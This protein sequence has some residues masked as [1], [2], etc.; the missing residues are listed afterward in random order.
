MN[1]CHYDEPI[2]VNNLTNSN[3]SSSRI[4][5][6]FNEAFATTSQKR[7]LFLLVHETTKVQDEMQ[8]IFQSKLDIINIALSA[9]P[10]KML[11]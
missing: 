4:E 9:D 7:L 1:N 10:I 5:S 6:I 2:E 8:N 11:I 3:S